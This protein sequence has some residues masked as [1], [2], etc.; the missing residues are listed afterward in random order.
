M[1]DSFDDIIK[2]FNNIPFKGQ[3]ESEHRK[4]NSDETYV[5]STFDSKSYF[6]DFI[7]LKL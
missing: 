1:I 2:P 5:D 3:K 6:D 7:E 4:I